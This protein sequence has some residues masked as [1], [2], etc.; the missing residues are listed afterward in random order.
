MSEN[1]FNILVDFKKYSYR[2]MIVGLLL[3][4]IV[5]VIAELLGIKLSDEVIYQISLFSNRL[6]TLGFTVYIVSLYL[7]L[8]N[9]DKFKKK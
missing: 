7:T 6:Y 9:I 8:K 3:P 2:T 1:T 4:F 5:A